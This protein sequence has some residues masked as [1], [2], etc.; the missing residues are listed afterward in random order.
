[1]RGVPVAADMLEKLERELETMEWPTK[2]R[3]KVQA[4]RYFIL[5]KPDTRFTKADGVKARV[6]A[7]RL[8]KHA[9]L[10]DLAQEA[11]ASV[12]AEFASKN[13]T[14]L[15]VTM[16][17]RDSPH[18]DT[19]NLG[20]FY[21]LALGN[22]ACV[23]GESS[24]GEAESQQGPALKRRRVNHAGYLA[25]EYSPHV[26][27]LVDT[28]RRFGKVD[29]RSPHWVT[30]YATDDTTRRYSLIFY[31]TVGEVQPKGSAI[32]GDFED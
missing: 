2:G 21:A 8:E 20:P 6:N 3:P 30:P 31:Q 13:F 1:M 14:A 18:I 9:V 4:Q 15:A 17:F 24:G 28:F 16:N 32:F 29:G 27:A 12:D 10:W 22:Y 26:V 5:N 25:V 11:L 23:G 7:E 19:E